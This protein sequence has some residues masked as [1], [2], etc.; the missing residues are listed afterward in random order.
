MALS[1]A[2]ERD[3]QRAGAE[4]NAEIEKVRI[5]VRIRAVRKIGFSIV[6]SVGAVAAG[7]TSP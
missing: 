7:I 2:W 4:D 1:L 6:G 3:K 5:P